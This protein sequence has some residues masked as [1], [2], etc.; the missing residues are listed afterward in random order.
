MSAQQK[1]AKGKCVLIVDVIQVL[2]SALCVTKDILLKMLYRKNDAGD[3]TIVTFKKFSQTS[4]FHK[5][6]YCL[7]IYV[8]TV[9]FHVVN[10]SYYNF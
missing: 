5:Y 6:I 4:T 7:L 9:A 3:V 8:M 1:D 10:T 2:G